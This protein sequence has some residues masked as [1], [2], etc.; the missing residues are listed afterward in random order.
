MK[1]NDD[2]GQFFQTMKGLRQGDP[3]S[4]VLFNLVA[5]MLVV[6]IKRATVDDQFK[7]LVPHLVDGGLSILQYADDTIL[8]I[9]DD[10]QQANNLKLVLST[11]EKVA[12]LKIIYH[13]SELFCFGAAKGKVCDYV[14]IYGCKEGNLPFK[15]LGIPMHFRR[16]LNK[17]WRDVDERFQKIE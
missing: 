12:G 4:L 17:D 10:L 6:L 3:L 15:Y 9:E 1:I 14:S 11:F 13:K 16:I 5:D 7:G 8:F 2:I